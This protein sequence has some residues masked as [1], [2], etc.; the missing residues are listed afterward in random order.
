MTE[1]SYYRSLQ[2][3]ITRMEHEQTFRVILILGFATVVPIGVYHRLRAHLTGE[4]L[5]RRQEGLFILLTLRP[6]A[7]AGMIGLITYMI[8]PSLMAWSSVPLPIWLR[9]VGVV[10]GI[11]AGVLLIVTF[12]ALGR[13]LTDTVVTREKHSLVTSGPYRWVRHPFYVAFISAVTANSL[14]A[15]NWYI[16]LTGG[17]AFGVVVLRTRIEEE[18]LLERFGDEYSRYMERTGRFFPRWDRSIRE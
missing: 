10:L 15:A 14:V 12:R 2:D 13:N 11:N 16:A 9:W 4:K 7:L 1:E 5:D 17:L 6:V 8:D 3:A 18:K